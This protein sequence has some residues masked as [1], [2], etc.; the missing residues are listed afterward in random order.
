M[1]RKV[2]DSLCYDTTV[3]DLEIQDILRILDDITINPDNNCRALEVTCL[4][5][6]VIPPVLGLTLASAALVP[7]VDNQYR[8]H[9][10]Q[11]GFRSG[12]GSSQIYAVLEP[13]VKVRI[14]DWWHPEF[15][16]NHNMEKLPSQNLRSENKLSPLK[17]YYNF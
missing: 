3:N 14:L 5:G 9:K 7:S 8:Y 1:R 13:V 4:R 16:H 12:I 6:N 10:L 15:P 11:L 2:V 17:N